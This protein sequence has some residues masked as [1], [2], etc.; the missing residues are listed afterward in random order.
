MGTERQTGFEVTDRL[1]EIKT[2]NNWPHKCMVD[3]T[4]T[5]HPCIADGSVSPL[6]TLSIKKIMGWDCTREEIEKLSKY[7]QSAIVD[8]QNKITE[9]SN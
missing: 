2:G 4:C 3:I 8:F 7:I 1:N 5:F 9:I 6:K